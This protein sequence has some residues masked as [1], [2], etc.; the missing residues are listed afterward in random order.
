[1]PCGRRRD[2]LD[3]VGVAILRTL[4]KLAEPAGCKEIAERAGLEVRKVMGKLR[5]LLRHG[6]VERPVKGKYVITEKGRRAIS[7]TE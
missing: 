2:P 4:V 3:E 6:Y 7:R 1:M 5:T